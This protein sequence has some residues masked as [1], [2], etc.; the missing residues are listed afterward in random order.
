M[1]RLPD[2]TGILVSMTI[3]GLGSCMP[4]TSA[5]SCLSG[6]PY[7]GRSSQHILTLPLFA[8]GKIPLSLILCFSLLS[9]SALAGVR[10]LC[11]AVQSTL[12]PS[13]SQLALYWVSLNP[14]LAVGP[15]TSSHYS[16]KDKN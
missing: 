7:Y 14:S 9:E 11:V 13:F 2:S 4:F 15:H 1:Q 8:F 6:L 12:S 10:L 3:S 16:T 5:T